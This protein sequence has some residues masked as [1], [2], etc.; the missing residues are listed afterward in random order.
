MA[1]ALHDGLSVNEGRLHVRSLSAAW[2]IPCQI[3][4]AVL[5]SAAPAAAVSW[6]SALAPERPDHPTAHLAKGK[7]LVA[8]RAQFDPSF[9]KAVILLVDYDKDGALGVIINRPTDVP[10]KVAL[11]ELKELRKRKD[12]VYLG[13]PV[14][15]DRMVLLLRTAKAPPRSV[16]I[17]DTVYASGSLDALKGCVRKGDGVRAYAGYAGWGPGQL[18]TEVAHGDWVIGPADSK[19]IFEGKPETMWE[20]MLERLSGDWA[21]AP[22][23]WQAAS[24]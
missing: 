16:L 12:R 4:L 19:I 7:F 10:L 8:T 21:E 14:A 11:P 22:Q 1:S 9:A 15:L 2:R 18:D 17:F 23:R 3:L 13:G 24:R 5:L 6:Q 20:N